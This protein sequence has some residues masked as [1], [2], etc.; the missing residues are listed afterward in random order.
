M[1]IYHTCSDMNNGSLQHNAAYVPCL[2][3]PSSAPHALLFAGSNT[4]THPVRCCFG[5]IE[6][7]G[8]LGRLLHG[9]SGAGL[10]AAAAAVGAVV[11]APL[12]EEGLFRGYIL[13]S[14]TKWMHPGT[15]AS[16]PCSLPRCCT[17]CVCVFVYGAVQALRVLLGVRGRGSPGTPRAGA[18]EFSSVCGCAPCC[19]CTPGVYPRVSVWFYAFGSRRQLGGAH[20]VP[21]SVQ[22]PRFGQRVSVGVMTTNGVAAWQLAS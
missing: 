9:S 22:W 2:A 1:Y 8:R 14:L 18:C 21:R 4:H 20:F 15:A 6:E 7:W 10:P 11:A 19:R 17:V 12:L 5:A 16:M 3:C 13:P